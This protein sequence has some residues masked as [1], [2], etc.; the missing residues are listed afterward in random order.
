MYWEESKFVS[1]TK[2]TKK[3]CFLYTGWAKSR[4]AVNIIY[5]LTATL[6]FAHAVYRKK[7]DIRFSAVPNFYLFNLVF[8]GISYEVA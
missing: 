2:Y 7:R 1:F 4:V 8:S 5:I 3:L 6:L